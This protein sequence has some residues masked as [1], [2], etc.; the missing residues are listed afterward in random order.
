MS[1]STYGDLRS[2][3]HSGANAQD[4]DSWRR[5]LVCSNAE[6]VQAL[7]LG[8]R[9][10]VRD[11]LATAI[12]SLWLA[13]GLYEAWVDVAHRPSMA[14]PLDPR[15]SHRHQYQRYA[16]AGVGM[17]LN[18][19]YVRVRALKGRKIRVLAT[20]GT[21]D[22]CLISTASEAIRAD[23]AAWD[24]PGEMKA[25][26]PYLSLDTAVLSTYES[27]DYTV[28][29]EGHEC[30]LPAFVAFVDELEYALDDSRY[31][32][33]ELHAEATSIAWS[34]EDAHHEV[35][36]R[37]DLSPDDYAADVV[38]GAIRTAHT[39][40]VSSDWRVRDECADFGTPSHAALG[41]MVLH[42][43][44]CLDDPSWRHAF[45]VALGVEDAP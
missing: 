37:F 2:L 32:A 30:S 16:A 43:D 45:L 3:A 44:Y 31:D 11:A 9:G 14:S 42:L 41:T 33:V 4:P 10:P 29:W 7:A 8:L 40:H 36:A 1:R 23:V 17:N 19:H 34:W 5:L 6:D 28:I 27:L 35:L 25:E 15:F 39:E 26:T 21:Y 12:E 18:C 24:G 38:L 13:V 22:P 20:G